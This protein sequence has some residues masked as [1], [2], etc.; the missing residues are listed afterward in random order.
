MKPIELAKKYMNCIFKSGDFFE[1]QSILADNLHFR[2]PYYEFNKAQDY[3]KSLEFDRPKDFN[4]KIIQTLEDNNKV[5]LVYRF[6]KPRVETI[7]T[8]IF[9]V[10][11]SKIIRI[12][13]V[14]DSGVF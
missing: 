1:L 7:I 5:C 11:N 10:K 3:I 13:L 6:Y 8:Q 14:F 12:I 4:Y 2:G 9:E